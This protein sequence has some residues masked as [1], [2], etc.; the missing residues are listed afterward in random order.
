MAATPEDMMRYS[1]INGKAAAINH[2]IKSLKIV[3]GTPT[4][5]QQIL[6]V[7]FSE[8]SCLEGR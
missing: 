1:L 5:T 7:Q 4:M 6:R 2:L 8:G 3:A